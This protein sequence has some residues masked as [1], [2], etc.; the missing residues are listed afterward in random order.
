VA[1]ISGAGAVQS[2]FGLTATGA[3]TEDNPA[4]GSNGNGYLVTWTV[5]LTNT[6]VT[7][8]EGTRMT[9]GGTVSDNPRLVLTGTA[10]G[11]QFNS[12]I[13]FAGGNYLV[14]YNDTRSGSRIYGTRVSPGG[15]IRDVDG[16]RI[17]PQSPSGVAEFTPDVASDGTTALVAWQQTGTVIRAARVQ[18][19]TVLDTT[20]LVISTL[21]VSAGAAEPAVAFNG[22][23]LVVWNDVRGT[24]S[25]R[26]RDVAGNRVKIDGTVLD[27]PGFLIT[28]TAPGSEEQLTDVSAAAGDDWVAAYC[29]NPSFEN[30][31]DGL[32][33]ISPK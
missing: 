29:T 6:N 27:G 8:L 7:H 24:G 12:S 13:A 30:G 1:S 26:H 17:S 16:F 4:V 11:S 14:V 32:R 33:S 28:N 31:H 21:D 18:A 10:T 19:K 25:G 9:G 3:I 5:H 15:V 2:T 20:P 22:T 23:F